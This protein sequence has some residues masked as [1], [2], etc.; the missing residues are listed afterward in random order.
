MQPSDGSKTY[1]AMKEGKRVPTLTPQASQKI[2]QFYQAMKNA[3][4][5]SLAA[6]HSKPLNSSSSNYCQ[7]LQEI[8]EEQRFEVTYVDIQEPSHSGQFRFS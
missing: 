7:L 3:P 1:T 8:A 6:L 5:K 2:T 4:G